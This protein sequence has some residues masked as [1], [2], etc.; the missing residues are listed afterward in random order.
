MTVFRQ[1]P[2]DKKTRFTALCALSV[3]LLFVLS[4]FEGIIN[5][6]FGVP[7]VKL[8]LSN[9]VVVLSLC[10][11]DFWYSFLITVLKIL[12][13]SF[14][15]GGFSSFLFTALGSIASFFSMWLLKAF[16]KERVTAVGVSALG[17]FFHITAQYF[18]SFL[19]MQ[20]D[21]VFK[22]L[23]VAILL[24]LF[25]SVFVGLIAQYIIK[26]WYKNES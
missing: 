9:L 24:T 1:F 14:F 17:G 13:N 2:T 3:A 7:G 8:G 5:F 25:S 18:A 23:T 16:L 26:G 21:A 4:F 11:G 12:I 19:V 20:T 10:T 6:N 22:M 15:Y